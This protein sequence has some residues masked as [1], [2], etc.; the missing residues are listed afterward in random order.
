MN[1]VMILIMGFCSVQFPKGAS[2]QVMNAGF[3]YSEQCMAKILRCSKRRP[4]KDCINAYPRWGLDPNQ[5]KV[6]KPE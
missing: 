5:G 3:N 1:E 4:V 2:T 6:R